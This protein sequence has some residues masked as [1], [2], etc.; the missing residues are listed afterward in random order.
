MQLIQ[1]LGGMKP[2]PYHCLYFIASSFQYLVSSSTELKWCPSESSIMS[3]QSL[4]LLFHFSPWKITGSSVRTQA[5]SSLILLAAEQNSPF[6]HSHCSPGDQT[7]AQPWQDSVRQTIEVKEF[8]L[9]H[10]PQSPQICCR[11]TPH[12]QQRAPLAP[13]STQ[14]PQLSCSSAQRTQGKE[15][16][17]TTSAPNTLQSTT[18]KTPIMKLRRNFKE[19]EIRYS[20]YWFLE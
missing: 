4:K 7:K 11:L 10:F 6:P 2:L 19:T 18:L 9:N 14:T 1:S 5:V 15:G 13:L 12:S 16:S 17:G 20:R 3:P 8:L